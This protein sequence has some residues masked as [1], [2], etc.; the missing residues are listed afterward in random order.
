MSSLR[1]VCPGAVQRSVL[2]HMQSGHPGPHLLPP[3]PLRGAHS[4]VQCRHEYPVIRGALVLSGSAP[5]PCSLSPGACSTLQRPRPPLETTLHSPALWLLLS[6]HMSFPQCSF[7]EGLIDASLMDPETSTNGDF[8]QCRGV[9]S[10]KP[11]VSQEVFVGVGVQEGNRRD[12]ILLHKSLCF[13][14]LF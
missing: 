5:S 13:Q 10:P 9:C 3:R 1:Q 6:R 4:V 8:S 2:A 7:P 12:S 11:L 14:S